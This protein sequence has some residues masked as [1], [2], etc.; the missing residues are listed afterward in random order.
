M[1][2]SDVCHS[3]ICLY[4][5]SLL[6]LANYELPHNLQNSKFVQEC[7]N[8]KHGR[9]LNKKSTTQ[10]KSNVLLHQGFLKSKLITVI[11]TVIFKHFQHEFFFFS[12]AVKKYE[13][14]R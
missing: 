12:G 5:L 3:K 10:K 1:T 13:P 4:D 9:Q 8:M 14:E 2:G 7:M 11:D 6:F